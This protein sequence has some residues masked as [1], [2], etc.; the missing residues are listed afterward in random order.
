ML[1]A[2]SYTRQLS[3]FVF[4][5]RRQ[6]TTTWFLGRLLDRN[7]EDREALKAQILIQD[8][9]GGKHIVFLVGHRFIMPGAFI[10]AAEKAHAAIV[11]NQEQIFERMLFLFPAV[12]E[13]LFVHIDRSVDRA[14]RPIMKKRVSRQA[15]ERHDRQH[16]R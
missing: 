13:A 12:M 14:F 9:L 6:F 8:T 2:D 10:G 11:R 16:C 7:V 3:I 5:F 4:L 1:N 15:Q